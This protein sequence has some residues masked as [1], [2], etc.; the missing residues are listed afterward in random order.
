MT[1]RSYHQVTWLGSKYY[2]NATVNCA[3]T[4]TVLGKLT[5]CFAVHLDGFGAPHRD[6]DT[7]DSKT[8]ENGRKYRGWEQEGVEINGGLFCLAPCHKILYLP[9]P[10][11]GRSSALRGMPTAMNEK[12]R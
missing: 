4:Q 7:S 11:L 2:R 9:R 3:A 12:H 8:K 5:E 6:R 10:M 1:P